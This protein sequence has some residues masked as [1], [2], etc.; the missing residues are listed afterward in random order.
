[1]TLTQTPSRSP[2]IKRLLVLFLLAIALSAAIPGYLHQAWGW[3]QVPP[4]PQAQQ[5]KQL[6][7]SG[8][9][10]PG[11]QTV[12]QRIVEI[13]GH[14]WSAQAIVPDSL[15]DPTLEA[16]TWL[17][18]R[19]Q[20]WEQDLPQIDW[21]DIDG[22]RQWQVD[23]QHQLRF[24]ASAAAPSDVTYSVNARFFRGWTTRRTDA[25]LQWYSWADGGS[26]APS[27]WFWADQWQQLRNRQRLAWVA[28][29]IQMPIPPFSEI[30]A[31]QPEAAA[32]AK[33]VQSTLI[34]T[35]FQPADLPS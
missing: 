31:V 24:A 19:P 2:L 7:Q 28:V 18:L 23:S 30:Q 14:K 20:V 22:A 34:T 27:H 26:S 21:V 11:W 4:L 13:G 15:T 6:R 5:L 17:L 8:L 9:T 3:Q 10:L 29:S 33:L 25:V 12:E 16:A 35:I 32:L 1:M